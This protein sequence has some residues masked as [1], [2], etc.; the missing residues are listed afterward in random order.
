ML[1][2]REIEQE[3]AELEIARNHTP[4]ECIFLAALYCIADHKRGKTENYDMLA[5][6]QAALPKPIYSRDAEPAISAKVEIS[7]NSEFLRSVTGK[8]TGEAWAVVDELMDNLK[9][10]NP[11]VYDSVIRKI[12]AL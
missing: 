7:G 10:V 8:D 11:R 3:I 5:Y 9:L 4:S 1:D 2:L 6:S 12:Q